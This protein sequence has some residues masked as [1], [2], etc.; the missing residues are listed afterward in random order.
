MLLLFDQKSTPVTVVCIPSV[1]SILLPYIYLQYLFECFMSDG[2][3]LIAPNNDLLFFSFVNCCPTDLI[4]WFVHPSIDLRGANIFFIFSYCFVPCHLFHLSSE[5]SKF[6]L[7]I[8]C[9]LAFIC[10]VIWSAW[11][12]QTNECLHVVCHFVLFHIWCV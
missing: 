3:S 4:C 6:H 12:D 10:L 7:A 8:P 11:S 9:R 5:G 2:D 1:D